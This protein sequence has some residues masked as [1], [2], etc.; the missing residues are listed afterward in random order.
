MSFK[1]M[2]WSAKQTVGNSS[3]K[4]ILMMLADRANDA[5]E[6]WPSLNT[7]AKDCEISKRTVSTHIKRLQDDGFIRI[8]HVKTG[9]SFASN[10]YHLNICRGSEN[11]AGVVREMQGGSAR[12]A[13]GSEGVSI[14]VVR[15]MHTNLSVEPIN[16]PINEPILSPSAQV[17]EED[18]ESSHSKPN[19]SAKKEEYTAAFEEFWAVYP[20]KKGKG[21]AFRSW[22]RKKLDVAE[23]VAA[24]EAQKNSFDWQKDNGQFIPHPQT[25]LNNSC[26]LD[27]DSPTAPGAFHPVNADNI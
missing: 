8:E 23:V 1:A 2:A 10:R 4:F 3:R 15:E 21:G 22:K 11:L 25:W 13:I 24:V 26:W 7:I 14:G 9:T 20:K 16:E 17:S 19:A 27:E 5:G 18:T 6:C 12:D